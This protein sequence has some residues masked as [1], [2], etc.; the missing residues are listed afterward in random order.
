MLVNKWINVT[1]IR[2]H[3][4]S[5]WTEWEMVYLHEAAR[6]VIRT[7]VQG[8]KHRARHTVRLNVSVVLI[9][10]IWW[11][12]RVEE[13]M[14]GQSFSELCRAV[15][16]CA[17]LCRAVQSRAEPSRQSCH[18][19]TLLPSLLRSTVYNCPPSAT[20]LANHVFSCTLTRWKPVLRKKT[21]EREET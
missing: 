2:E 14:H 11:Y 8:T 13:N 17:E 15:Q 21:Q 7:G 6:K 20:S 19:A 3:I 1:E 16:S 18:C 5:L 9:N 12:V 4:P 10:W